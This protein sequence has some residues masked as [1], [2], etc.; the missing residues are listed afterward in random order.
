MKG[1]RRDANGQVSTGDRD[2][3]HALSVFLM[4]PERQTELL[5]TLGVRLKQPALF[6]LSIL[7]MVFSTVL[8]IKTAFEEYHER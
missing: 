2:F 8:G 5:A 3:Y 4:S 1:E 7:G 6:A